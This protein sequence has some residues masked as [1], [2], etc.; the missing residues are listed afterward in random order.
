VSSS[1]LHSSVLPWSPPPSSPALPVPRRSM[2]ITN[3][4]SSTAIRADAS[5]RSRQTPIGPCADSI[6]CWGMAGSHGPLPP[7]GPTSGRWTSRSSSR[8]PARA[9]R[10]SAVSLVPEPGDVLHA[11][12]YLPAGGRPAQ[13]RPAIL[14]LH[15]TVAIAGRMCGCR[16]GSQAEPRL[17]PRTGPAGLRGHRA[18]LSLLWRLERPQVRHATATCRAQ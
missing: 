5:S 16:P 4:C 6:S 14:A 2:L 8:P 18:R 10:S 7:N 15:P 11:D 12:L 17:C 13:R 9:S 1:G 3:S